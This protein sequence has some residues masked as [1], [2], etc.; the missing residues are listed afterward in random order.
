MSGETVVQGDGLLV[1]PCSVGRQ[2]GRRVGVEAI[3]LA[4]PAGVEPDAGVGAEG[5]SGSVAVVGEGRR[6]CG[7]EVVTG[8]EQDTVGSVADDFHQKP[9]S[10]GRNDREGVDLGGT[11]DL[12]EEAGVHVN[13]GKGSAGKRPGVGVVCV[14]RGGS[15]VRGQEG[16]LY[17]AGS[18][19]EAR[20]SSSSDSTPRHTE[21][22]L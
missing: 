1:V 19:S 12:S 9:A 6:T 13:G 20:S 18:A 4:L 17:G 5:G 3:S 8:A 16:A 11:G 15:S 10:T 7:L 2:V 14:G 22:S 21:V